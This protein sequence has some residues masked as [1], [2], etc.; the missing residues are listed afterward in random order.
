MRYL[1]FFVFVN[2]LALT[3]HGATPTMREIQ[4]T[5]KE[6]FRQ[7]QP[8]F[9]VLHGRSVSQDAFNQAHARGYRLYGLYNGSNLVSMGAY[10]PYPTVMGPRRSVLKDIVRH[11]DE[12]GH[13]RGDQ[14]L[15]GL[16]FKR[17]TAGEPFL[18]LHTPKPDGDQ[19][20]AAQKCYARAHGR[21]VATR[22]RWRR[23]EE[24]GQLD[25][26]AKDAEGTIALLDVDQAGEATSLLQQHYGLAT[27]GGLRAAARN[28]LQIWGLRRD[29]R[30]R[31]VAVADNYPHP[32]EESRGW[33]HTVA[34][35]KDR[36]SDPDRT[37]LLAHAISELFKQGAG[38]VSQGIGDED[39]L[40]QQ[41]AQA[42]PGAVASSPIYHW[43][44]PAGTI[45]KNQTHKKFWLP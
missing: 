37:T 14:T 42:V 21:Q 32:Q 25:Q 13:H 41:T 10:R 43:W 2:G 35:W 8:L 11:P 18:F 6:A 20:T 26:L 23:A 16:I 3:A 1:C 44:Q 12:R 36:E 28:G 34:T 38:T 22:W 9:E 5:H 15:V 33:V 29:G 31:G 30:L 17:Q 39:L 40:R 7:T 45:Y 19:L 4:P 27:P 24:N